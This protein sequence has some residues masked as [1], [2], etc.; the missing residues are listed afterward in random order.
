[1]PT[2]VFL[3]EL[4]HNRKEIQTCNMI[5]YFGYEITQILT[6]MTEPITDV[7]TPPKSSNSGSDDE[8][9]QGHQQHQQEKDQCYTPRSCFNALE[10]MHRRYASGG[11]RIATQ[12][13]YEG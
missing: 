10:A 2:G 6:K 1:M 9:L 7:Q 11:G 12:L 4:I 13:S 3:R 5:N 8:N